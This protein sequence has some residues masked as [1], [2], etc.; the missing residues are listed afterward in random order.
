[1]EFGAWHRDTWKHSGLRMF[2]RL[3][4]LSFYRILH[5]VGMTDY[6]IDHWRLIQP[7][8]S[9]LHPEVS[10]MGLKVTTLNYMVGSP[11]NRHPSI[12]VFQKS[13]LH[14]LQGG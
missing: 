5:Y 2:L 3:C 1:M 4:P 9:L 13:L 6:I 8:A 10:G 14:K 12:D 11:G 7:Q